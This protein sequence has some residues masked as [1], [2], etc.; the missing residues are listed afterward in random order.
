MCGISAIIHCASA[1]VSPEHLKKMNDVIQHRGP[2]GE[3][4]Y[5]DHS[6]GLG[7]R[8]LKIM[9]VT[10]ENIQPMKFR[11]YVVSYNGEIYNFR[12][13]RKSLKQLGYE[14]LTDTDTEVL[15]SAYDA[16]KEN[17]VHHFNGMWAF[18]LYDKKRQIIFASRDRFGIK[19]LCYTHSH[20]K[21]LIASEIKQFTVFNDF[22]ARLN[23][24]V[25]F[26]YLYAGRLNNDCES[27]F[28]NIFF[29]P[30]GSNLI[31]DLH[32]HTYNIKKWYE[33]KY[34]RQHE[35][36]TPEETIGE[37]RRLLQ[38]SVSDHLY[39][40]V[41]TGACLS[42]G[43]DS[44]S[45]VAIANSLDTKLETYSSCFF[46]EPFDESHYINEATDFYKVSNHK[47]YPLIE[48]L[49]SRGDLEK[50]VYQHDQPITC[51]SFH[52]EYK[53]FELASKH[54]TRVILGGSGADEY[55][56]GYGEYNDVYLQSLIN[57]K[58]LLTFLAEFLL[59]PRLK[60]RV[61]E[62]LRERWKS[63]HQV[64]SPSEIFISHSFK[65]QWLSKNKTDLECPKDKS[66][67]QQLSIFEVMKFSLPHQLHSEDRSSMYFSM[68]SRVPYLDHR[69]VEFCLSLPDRYKFRNGIS[70]YILRKS[71][72]NILPK[73]IYQRRNKIGMPGSEKPLFKN[74]LPE[75]TNRYKELIAGFPQI[76]TDDLVNMLRNYADG[77]IPYNNFLFRVLSF[78][79]WTRSFNVSAESTASMH[80]NKLE[81][82][83]VSAT[84]Y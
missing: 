29:L 71:M 41:P 68:E 51:G 55:L 28:E 15:L 60:I 61:V 16:W 12:E 81:N 80:V 30:A 34:H 24:R 52:S 36:V 7:H 5:V 48:E 74:Y 69:L 2:D 40:R 77:R 18:V 59:L 25:A 6:V 47:V 56:A 44:T 43:L 65:K 79:A 46:A 13:L 14:F 66:N 45:I 19:P 17:C 8:M 37:F 83:V 38:Q 64:N 27:M 11:D 53:I 70:K 58:K 73:G 31:Y 84:S 42:G 10:S 22:T 3:G 23:H 20:H 49:I 63:T 4:Y 35:D 78:D 62:M 26:E 50:I 54:N 72:R 9:D 21:F 76:F 39:S 32:S 33:L 1:P 57:N 75:I 67:I 82:A